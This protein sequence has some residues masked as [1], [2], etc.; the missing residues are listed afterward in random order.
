[1]CQALGWAREGGV[2]TCINP[3]V[4]CSAVNSFAPVA[5]PLLDLHHRTCPGR[6]CDRPLLPPGPQLPA[7]RAC[8]AGPGMG[9]HEAWEQ[10]HLLGAMPR[11]VNT[12]GLA[13]PAAALPAAP[14]AC[15]QQIGLFLHDSCMPALPCQFTARWL[16]DI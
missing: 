1:M 3:G 10:M 11:G 8:G 13:C 6:R 15:A 4:H 12:R 7:V 2:C 16:L 9:Q 14:P 5:Q